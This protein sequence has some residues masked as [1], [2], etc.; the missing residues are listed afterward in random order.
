MIM[1][2]GPK[3]H[4]YKLYLVPDKDPSKPSHVKI[5]APQ[6]FFRGVKVGDQVQFIPDPDAPELEGAKVEVEFESKDGKEKSPFEVGRI[7]S[8]SFHEFKHAISD[9]TTM[10]YLTTSDGVRHGY[11]EDGQHPCAGCLG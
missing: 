8:A 5:R 2:A 11:D 4:T 10:C 6:D 3:T 7:Q 9:F 1:A